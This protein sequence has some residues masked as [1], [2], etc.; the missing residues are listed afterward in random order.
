M[1]DWQAKAEEQ[2]PA[3]LPFEGFASIV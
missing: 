1:A 2:R 3:R